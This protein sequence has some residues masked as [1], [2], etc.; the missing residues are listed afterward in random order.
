[1]RVTCISYMG[2]DYDNGNINI[3]EKTSGPYG[4]SFSGDCIYCQSAIVPTPTQTTTHTPTERVRCRL[5]TSAAQQAGDKQPRESA[6]RI[7]L[8]SVVRD[9]MKTFELP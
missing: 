1:M 2:I 9:T 3:I 7:G 5:A 4:Y 8:F 6:V